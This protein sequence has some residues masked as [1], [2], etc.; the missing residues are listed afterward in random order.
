MNIPNIL[1]CVECGFIEDLDTFTS[2]GS[3]CPLCKK[4]LKVASGD[5]A[6]IINLI[7]LRTLDFK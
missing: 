1:F 2:T 3:E 6:N 7:R 4:H 5:N